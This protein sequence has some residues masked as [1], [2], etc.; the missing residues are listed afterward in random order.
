M[1]LVSLGMGIEELDGEIGKGPFR[2][3]FGQLVRWV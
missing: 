1:G 3:R 2:G